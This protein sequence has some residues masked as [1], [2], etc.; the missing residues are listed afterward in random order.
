[1]DF[2][3]QLEQQHAI[4]L[5]DQQR[6]AVNHAGGP[7]LLLSVPG[8][9]KT[10]VIVCRARKL[11]LDGVR[12]E[13][14]LTMS[15]NRAAARDMEARYRSLFGDQ[16]PLPRFQTIHSLCYGLLKARWSRMSGEALQL[17]ETG[18]KM[19]LLRAL[20]A[21]QLP[22]TYPSEEDLQKLEQDIGYCKNAL[23]SP[24]LHKRSCELPL[25]FEA[26]FR[27][28]NQEN[29]RLNRMD[30]D[31][32]LELTRQ[33]LFKDGPLLQDFQRRIRYIQLDE[34]QDVSLLQ[35]D[36]LQKLAAPHN[37]LMMV[38][39][40][41]QSIYGFRAAN[42][43]TLLAFESLFPGGKVMRME[44][45]FR[46]C[47][48]IVAAAGRFIGQNKSRYPKHMV[49]FGQESGEIERIQL[50]DWAR[51]TDYVVN[52]AQF[53]SLDARLGILYRTND[54]AMALADAL[55]AAGI[56]FSLREDAYALLF[57]HRLTRELL[58]MLRLSQDP[59]DRESFRQICFKLYPYSTR[60]MLDAFLQ[61]PDS[62]DALYDFA[63]ANG[64]GET[65][66]KR[67]EENRRLMNLAQ[68]L[69]VDELLLS[70]AVKLQFNCA[71]FPIRLKLKTLMSIARRS[72]SVAAFLQRVEALKAVCARAAQARHPVCLSSIHGAKG[73]EYDEVILVDGIDGLFPG[74]TDQDPAELEEERRLF[75]VCCTRAKNRLSLIAS[76]HH[77]GILM[78]PSR[79][80]GEFMGDKQPEAGSSPAQPRPAGGAKPV[81]TPGK[82]GF[83][84]Y[85]PQLQLKR[86]DTPA[87][88]PVDL[89]E[90][91][92]QKVRHRSFG[93]GQMYRINY[94]TGFCE[95][96]FPRIGRKKL[97]LR[98]AIRDGILT[99]IK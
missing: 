45:N 22:D 39:D 20:I 7:A 12:P 69:P 4:R 81:L 88:K 86:S 18:E 23:I 79:F 1:M 9:G 2:F 32:M 24:R 25:D 37:H 49:A 90:W 52:R 84:G 51:Q 62:G 28:Y 21:A 55:D 83:T 10:T 33:A 74:L 27:A 75:Y 71:L 68:T 58:A 11:I 16:G 70:Y 8:S 14:I 67:L 29:A 38:G 40:E 76:R 59:S 43:K 94:N 15:F 46:S 85:V 60:A 80:I 35:H 41:D 31:D 87:A 42:P 95:V 48:E 93:E 26:L 73:L 34:A 63:K 72:G 97:H 66:A 19:K 54:S 50:A 77:R 6:Q 89:H 13:A 78:E 96:T 47:R 92:N 64:L 36:I 91:E 17:L 82:V 61:A 3:S 57:S 56:D 99:L 65:I 5:T 98:N 30:Y 53:L 44:T